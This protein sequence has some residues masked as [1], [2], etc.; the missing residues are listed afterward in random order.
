MLKSAHSFLSN[1]VRAVAAN[2][3]LNT[4]K[5]TKSLLFTF[6]LIPAAIAA[7]GGGGN[8]ERG[9]GGGG[10]PGIAPITP[11]VA[12]EGPNPLIAD[13]RGKSFAASAASAAWR[14]PIDDRSR[15]GGGGIKPTPPPILWREKKI[16]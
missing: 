16:G 6:L 1:A 2:L 12:P 14:N 5:T 8:P 4:M 15:G 7:E 3:K 13:F 11:P 10:K 9:G